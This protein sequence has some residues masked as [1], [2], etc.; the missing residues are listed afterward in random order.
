MVGC[1]FAYS[2]VLARTWVALAWDTLSWKFD[3]H[4][5]PGTQKVILPNLLGVRVSDGDFIEPD[6]GLVMCGVPV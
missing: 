3:L 2:T 6:A 4:W 5:F 1:V